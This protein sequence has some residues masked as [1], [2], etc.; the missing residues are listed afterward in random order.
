ALKKVM[1]N[2]TTLVIAHRL[3]TIENADVILV[4]QH[5]QIIE[6]G[7]HTELL[8]KKGVYTRLHQTKDMEP[9]GNNEEQ[10]I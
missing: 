7:T 3:S 6:K 1:K 5:G 2:R 10:A 8:A 4:M 9:I